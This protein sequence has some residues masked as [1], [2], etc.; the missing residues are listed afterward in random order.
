[1]LTSAYNHFKPLQEEVTREPIQT[2]LK[3]SKLAR[4]Q[5]YKNL[6]V[7]PLLAP[8]GTKPDY[9]TLDQ[10]LD[11]NLVQIT[12]LDTAGSVP[13]LRLIKRCSIICIN[14]RMIL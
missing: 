14:I 10:G 5:S 7:F 11:Q 1:M 12:E 13:E 3:R 2:F 6:T 8:N 4:K 9:L